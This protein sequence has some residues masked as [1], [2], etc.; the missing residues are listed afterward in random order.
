MA[1]N[2]IE[3]LVPQ[4]PPVDP[5]SSA[6]DLKTRLEWGEPAFTIIDVR[7]RQS[8]NDSH[9][10]GAIS[11]TMDVLGNSAVKSLAKSRDIYVYGATEEEGSQAVQALKSAGFQNVSQLM[12][13]LAGWKAIG[14]PTEGYS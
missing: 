2:P 7:D 10:M 13:G 8:Y 5:K 9:I 4:Q 12:G 1:N 3:N 11:M 6:N 14:G